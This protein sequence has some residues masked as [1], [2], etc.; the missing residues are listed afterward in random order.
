MAEDEIIKH[1]K[2]AYKAWKNPDKNWKEKLQ[3]ISIE[4]VIIVFAVSISIWLHNLSEASSNRKEEKEFLTGLKEDLNGDIQIMDSVMTFYNNQFNGLAYYTKVGNGDSLVKD[5]LYKYGDVFLSST[6]FQPK[7]S[8]YEGF[9]GS[10][11]F[12]IIENQKLL[13]NI[14]HVHEETIAHIQILNKMYYN[15]NND[16]IL[17]FLYEHLQLDALGNPVNVENVL[18]NSEMRFFIKYD[19]SF[20]ANSIF[21]N[22]NI[23]INECN[24]IISQIDEE[25]KK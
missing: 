22:Y 2:A 14:I 12:N 4:I 3:E 10:G 1:T 24:D 15:F 18:R 21:A 8:R 20:I 7:T 5:S 17:P 23:A 16:R 9:K 11:R 13:D 19:R 6:D 25:L